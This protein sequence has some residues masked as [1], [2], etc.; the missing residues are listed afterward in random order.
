M[1]LMSANSFE[2]GSCPVLPPR[3]RRHVRSRGRLTV[4]RRFP[5][6]GQPRA[7]SFGSEREGARPLLTAP[8]RSTPRKGW[9]PLGRSLLLGVIFGGGDRGQLGRDRLDIGCGDLGD[10]SSHPAFGQLGQRQLELGL[11]NTDLG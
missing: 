2:P 9:S 7:V 3:R 11:A 5:I 8:P 6:W 4:H 1:P 10:R